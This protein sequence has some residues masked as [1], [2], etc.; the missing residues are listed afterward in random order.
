MKKYKYEME[1]GGN[2]EAEADS[3]AKSLTTLGSR[4]S[5]TEL[6]RLERVVL[7]EPAKLALAKRALGL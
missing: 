7:H 4:L 2:T 1:I 5:A 3:K 6:E